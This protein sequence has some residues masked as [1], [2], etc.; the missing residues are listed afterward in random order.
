M[1][2]GGRIGALT[3][4]GFVLATVG[5]TVAALGVW[6]RATTVCLTPADRTVGL[7]PAAACGMGTTEC[8][9]LA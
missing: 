2:R 6:N 9:T 7:D 4:G 8:R 5:E 3:V 1:D